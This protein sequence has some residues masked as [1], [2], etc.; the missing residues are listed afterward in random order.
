MS[1]EAEVH[2]P[3]TFF[4]SRASTGTPSL[5]EY[6]PTLDLH[7]IRTITTEESGEGIFVRFAS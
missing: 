6:T 1:S 4:R 5:N 3:A 2:L 7:E